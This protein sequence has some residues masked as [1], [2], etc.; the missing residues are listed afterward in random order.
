LAARTKTIRLGTSV[1]ILP[2]RNPMATAKMFATLDQFSG[3]RVIVGVGS[4]WAEAEF[5]ALGIPFRERG[6]RTTEYLSILRACWAPGPTS[7]KGK[8]FAFEGMHIN[9][10][11]VQQPH[12]P[13]LIGGSGDGVLRR[14]ARFAEIWQ[15]MQMAPEELRVK[16][17]QLNAACVAEGRATPPTT[18]LSVRVTFAAPQNK[19][20]ASDRPL[21]QGTPEQVA[22]D[23]LRYRRDCGVEA[24]QI[25]FGGCANVA[26]LKEWMVLFMREVKPQVAQ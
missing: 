10:K 20:E 23:L 26:Q 7:F 22:A 9:P 21:G 8:F 5:N 17:A 25:N 15:P 14:A 24:F 2:Y 18:R 16:Q 1:L 6:A 19:S 11:P 12:P 3:G 13:I 4:G